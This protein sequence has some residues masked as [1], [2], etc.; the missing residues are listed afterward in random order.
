MQLF[1]FSPLARVLSYG[2]SELLDTDTG[3]VPVRTAFSPSPAYSM[4]PR[5]KQSFFPLLIQQK[6][7]LVLDKLWFV[8]AYY[9]FSPP[10]HVLIK[11][12]IYGERGNINE[13]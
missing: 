8:V 12:F 5:T 3:S 11:Y 13:R 10:P 6:C 2:D 4:G 7:V 1:F 9:Y